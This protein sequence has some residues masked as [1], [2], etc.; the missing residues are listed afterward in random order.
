[1]EKSW[2][3]ALSLKKV[4]DFSIDDFAGRQAQQDGSAAIR[5]DHSSEGEVRNSH[6]KAG[7]N[8]FVEL[9]GPESATIR[10][11][12]NDVSKAGTAIAV[13]DGATLGSAAYTRYK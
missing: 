13:S 8:V 4:S 12:D 2:R 6:A 5:I 7:C 9:L 3:N 10:L 1:V 11:I